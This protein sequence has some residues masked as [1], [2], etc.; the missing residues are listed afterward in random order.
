MKLAIGDTAPDFVLNTQDGTPFRLSDAWRKGPVV[1][2]FYP[3]DE[4]SGCTAEACSFRDSYE[5]FQKAGAQVVGVSSDS[6]EDHRSFA[7]HHR[8]PFTLLADRGGAVRA[9]YEVPKTLG[10][11]MGRVTYVLDRGGTIRHIFNSQIHATRH[12][13]EA[14][15]VLQKLQSN[16]ESDVH[17]S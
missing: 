13:S 5:D 14:L 4:T 15:S 17:A 1:L 7:S 10:I 9:L 6:E 8:L 2:Y 12:V 16:M 11:L 3:K